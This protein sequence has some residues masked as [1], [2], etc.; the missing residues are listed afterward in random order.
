MNK[1]GRKGEK[2]GER[3][4]GRKRGGE[5]DRLN[6]CKCQIPNFPRAVIQAVRICLLFR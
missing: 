3:E 2:E 1:E 6:R 4:G 5:P